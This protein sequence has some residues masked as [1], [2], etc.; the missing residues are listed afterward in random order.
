MGALRFWYSRHAAVLYSSIHMG[1][2]TKVKTLYSIMIEKQRK[3]AY[4][5][6]TYT[7]SFKSSRHLLKWIPSTCVHTHTHK[8]SK[9]SLLNP[10]HEKKNFK[11]SFSTR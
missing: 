8:T 9:G 3:T 2:L 4:R 6:R 1:R 10:E 5:T 7:P 11:I